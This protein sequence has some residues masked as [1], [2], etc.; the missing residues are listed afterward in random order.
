VLCRELARRNLTPADVERYI[1]VSERSKLRDEVIERGGG[2]RSFGLQ[3]FGGSY[4]NEADKKANIQLRTKWFTISGIPLIPI[5]S[6]RFKC[7]SS[8]GKRFLTNTPQ[9]VVDRVPL[10]WAQV[11]MT[12]IKTALLLIAAGL[13]MVGFFGI[14][15]EEGTRTWVW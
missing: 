8:S 3:F 9:R 13:L 12:W 7:T 11:F 2:Y 10:N 4:L 1:A 14:W 6:Y 5:S 15:T